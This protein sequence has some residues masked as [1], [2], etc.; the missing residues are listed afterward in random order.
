MGVPQNGWFIRE[1]L[2]KL[3]IWGYPYLWKP[4]HALNIYGCGKELKLWCKE[5]LTNL[6]W[7]SPRNFE[8]HLF[9]PKLRNGLMF[10]F[11]MYWMPHEQVSIL[12]VGNPSVGVGH[13]KSRIIYWILTDVLYGRLIS[14]RTCRK[15]IDTKVNLVLVFGLNLDHFL[16]RFVVVFLNINTGQSRNGPIFFFSVRDVPG[17]ISIQRLSWSLPQTR[18]KLNHQLRP[19]PRGSNLMISD[20]SH[21]HDRIQIATKNWSWIIFNSQW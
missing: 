3:M 14:L 10:I 9:F 20:V 12:L 15:W 1:I 11:F 21:R 6:T 7:N 13:D 2:L 5:P 18:T 8:H 4:P 19:S 16:S 17:S